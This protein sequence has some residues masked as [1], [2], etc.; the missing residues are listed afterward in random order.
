MLGRRVAGLDVES[1]REQCWFCYMVRCAD[2]SL[3]VGIA[4][5]VPE[6]V[7][8]HNSGGG[9]DFTARRRPVELIWSECCGS[10]DAARQ[11][12][13]EIKG[14]NRRKKLALLG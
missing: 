9:P 2:D 12:E 1:G 6:R 4:S 11:R 3:Y 8:R 5:D 7:K 14:W 13:K 10:S